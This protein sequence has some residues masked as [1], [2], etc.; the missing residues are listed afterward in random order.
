[1]TAQKTEM[2]GYIRMKYD[3]PEDYEIVVKQG[4]ITKELLN[5]FYPPEGKLR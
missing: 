2:I 4:Y 3:V 5:F 1:M